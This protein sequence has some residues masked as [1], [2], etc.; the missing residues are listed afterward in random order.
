MVF[1]RSQILRPL[2]CSILF[3]V[4][5]GLSGGSGAQALSFGRKVFQIRTA[6]FVIHYPRELESLALRLASFADREKEGL[7]SLYGRDAGYPIPVLLSDE[8]PDL[9]GYSTSRP[10]DR[11]VIHVAASGLT[12]QLAGLDD[13]LRSVFVHELTHSLNFRSRSPFWSFL[14][15]I[16]GD[17]VNPAMWIMPSSFVEGSAVFSE[18]RGGSGR[19]NDSAAQEM[20]LQAV[21]ERRF[22]SFN[23]LSGAMDSWNSGSI[24]Y[25]FGGGFVEYLAATYGKEKPGQLWEDAGRGNFLSGFGGT[26]AGEGT[27][28]A[29]FG[30]NLGEA[31]KDYEE[32]LARPNPEPLAAQKI[33][34]SPSRIVALCASGD[35]L[36][37]ADA[38]AGAVTEMDTATGSERHLFAA[39]GAV[40][41][42][43]AS[44]DGTKLLVSWRKENGKGL[45]VPTVLTFGRDTGAKSG[46][47]LTG[48]RSATWD[49][50]GVVAVRDSGF[51][52]SLLLPDGSTI[53]DGSEVGS[54]SPDF[55]V[56]VVG[57]SGR[58]YALVRVGGRTGIGKIDTHT[59]Q[60]LLL[61]AGLGQPRSLSAGPGGAILVSFTLPGSLSRLAI[62]K[63][64]ETGPELEMQSRDI[65]GGVHIPVMTDSGELYYA[66]R[67]VSGEYLCRLPA[68]ILCSMRKIECAWVEAGVKPTVNDRAGE[69]NAREDEEKAT[70]SEKT[71]RDSAEGAAIAAAAARPEPSP[72]LPLLFRT[73]RLPI[74]DA[75]GAGIFIQGADLTERLAWSLATRYSW[76][77]SGLSASLRVSAKSGPLSLS[78]GV[79]DTF[80]EGGSVP[81][82]G[83]RIGGTGLSAAFSRS[84]APERRRFGAGAWMNLAA[85]ADGVMPGRAYGSPWSFGSASAGLKAGYSDW[86]VSRYAPFGTKGFSIA[87]GPDI[88]LVLESAAGAALCFSAQARAALPAGFE[89]TLC[90]AFSPDGRV[91]FGPVSRRLSFG[92]GSR[93]SA[94]AIPYP[95]FEEYGAVSASSPWYAF[96]EISGRAF[97]AEIQRGIPFPGFGTPLYLRRVTGRAGF[98]LAAFEEKSA[99]GDP[100][101]PVVFPASA[102]FRIEAQLAL[103][104]SSSFVSSVRP[105]AEVSWA[106]DRRLAPSAF[107]LGIYL[108]VIQ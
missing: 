16:A 30:K 13:T 41:R 80:S 88:E 101:S 93:A 96:A 48:I 104:Q 94:V 19:N 70:G 74:L 89:F 6:H 76:K 105:G 35:S 21:V 22:P 62:L 45:T 53:G 57:K 29:V 24:P 32:S 42:I 36:F 86:L 72:A 52:S 34:G 73:F 61:D 78:F 102:F 1:R 56:P 65:S 4:I 40:E 83:L 108:S 12:G 106:T 28:R 107:R 3:L 68:E 77:Y 75:T 31:W 71:A 67:F 66:G 99:A 58:L 46:S 87:A 15:G 2:F 38:E 23:Q 26:L 49:G 98:R 14:A 33:R 18:S 5:S 47:A 7:E 90:G 60:V 55:D 25:I 17:A 37:I 39:D 85:L 10:S 95:A 59:G 27:F 44:A 84:F 11:I 79:S 9:N 20:I 82:S 81:G 54:L 8:F 43:E 63:D 100:A 97:S 51:R 91:A 92:S 69:E 103:T 64:G 50:N